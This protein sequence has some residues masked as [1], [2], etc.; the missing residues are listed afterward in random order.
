M[1]IKYKEEVC[2]LFIEY[3]MNINQ[4]FTIIS[5][6]PNLAEAPNW[7]SNYKICTFLV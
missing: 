7:E 5:L 6:M 4:I 2:Q 1:T 3:F